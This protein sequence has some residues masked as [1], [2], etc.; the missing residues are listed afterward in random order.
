[1]LYG[2]VFGCIVP[3][4]VKAW[5]LAKGDAFDGGGKDKVAAEQLSEGNC[6]F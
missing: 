5:Q 4:P 3:I 6:L 2:S 1:M